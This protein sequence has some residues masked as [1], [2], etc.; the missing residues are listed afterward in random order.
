MLA[1]YFNTMKNYI[2]L[3]ALF[4]V[5][6]KS[7]TCENDF[8]LYI[9]GNKFTEETYNTSVG[10]LIDMSIS[11]TGIGSDPLAY[12]WTVDGKV[13]SNNTTVDYNITGS[14][15]ASVSVSNGKCTTKKD[16]RINTGPVSS[17]TCS[18]GNE[19]NNNSLSSGITI[20]PG[21][22]YM[23]QIGSYGD[24]DYYTLNTTGSSY[25]TVDL[26][27][28][29]LNYNVQILNSS[30]ST[31]TG[32][33]NTST[34]NESLTFAG[35]TYTTYY[36]R[37]YASSSSDYSTSDCYNLYATL[38]AIPSCSNSYEPNNSIG[39]SQ[40]IPVNSTIAS[41][42]AAYDD[43]DYYTFT[44]QSGSTNIKINLTNLPTDYDLKLYN[45]SYTQIGSSTSGSNTSEEIKYASSSPATYYVYVY[46]YG[47][48]S[49]SQCYNLRVNTGS[50][51]FK[52]V[53]GEQVAV[54]K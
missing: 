23:S 54:P 43:Y 10:S 31:L 4:L 2:L 51:P 32:S 19:P 36:I 26:T 39:A 13:I 28:L 52:V 20:Q 25:I 21:T 14:V 48:Y 1:Y 44:T 8:N 17:G 41:Q 50:S 3:S 38:S 34:S 27:S 45:S 30:G 37:V 9:E 40:T 49:T 12:T 53:E 29:P 42:L 18:D 7:K 46:P 22:T 6:C 15:D 11:S 35:S 16:F 5:T 33:Y 47:G 24:Y